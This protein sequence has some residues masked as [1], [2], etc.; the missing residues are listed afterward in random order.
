[1]S[2]TG[3][4]GSSA[5]P[6]SART[7]TRS[8]FARTMSSASSWRSTPNRPSRCRRS[9]QSCWRAMASPLTADR[10]PG[11]ATSW[12]RRSG[13]S[14]F[15]RSA[16]ADAAVAAG[17]AAIDAPGLHEPRPPAHSPETDRV[18]HANEVGRDAVPGTEVSGTAGSGTEVPDL[19]AVA[20]LCT[21]L[22]RI[23]NAADA[24]PL[25]EEVARI[26]DATGLVVWMWDEAGG[27]L[28]PALAYGYSDRVLAQL[29]AVRRD[30]DNAT[31]A[32]FRLARTCAVDGGDR[33]SGALVVPLLT[34]AG[35]SGVLALELQHRGE[36]APSRRSSQRCW[37]NSCREAGG[38]AEDPTR[39]HVRLGPEPA[40][41]L[42]AAVGKSP[43]S[44]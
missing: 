43:T 19:L 1:M 44:R 4:P 18:E 7:P 26:L 24:R 32:A 16:A 29:P 37:R 28:K 11:F 15:R 34:A 23:A 6:T 20:D 30:S 39:V 17:A 10:P 22:G 21:R 41:P 14:R 40:D 31:A 35:C 8:A 33:T 9:R 25:L 27:A 12:D 13:L 38:I 2:R 3:R 5:A 42:L 36:Q